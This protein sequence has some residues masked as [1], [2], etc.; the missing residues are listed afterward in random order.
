MRVRLRLF[1]TAVILLTFTRTGSA[2]R[3]LT[4]DSTA[5]RISRISLVVTAGYAIPGAKWP[6][7]Q[8]WKGG[9][10]LGASVLIHATPGLYIGMG[11]DV[12]MLWFRVSRFA[13][14][15][16][17]VPVHRTDM[18]WANLFLV[19]RYA[20]TSSGPV[21]PYASA[22]IGA[23]RLSGGEYKEIIDSVRVTY[24]DIPARTRL[25]MTVA[26]GLAIPLTPGLFFQAEAALRYVHHDPNVGLGVIF[27]G[28][29]R[30]VL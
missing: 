13:S 21:R 11:A 6:L 24:Y 4:P 12:S 19:S 5:P 20:F 17:S 2:Q 16:P 10:E 3:L 8:F 28:G 23:S 30:I 9:P 25:A 29:A 14:A 7:Q 18:A 1:T 26:G 15:Y 27:N 22:A